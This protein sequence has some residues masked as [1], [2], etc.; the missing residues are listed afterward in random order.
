MRESERNG[1][2][3]ASIRLDSVQ[4]EG[5]SVS[6]VLSYDPGAEITY[7]K[8]SLTDSTLVKTE[9]LQAYLDIREGGI[10]Y[11][12]TLNSL[13]VRMD[14]LEFIGLDGAPTL[15]FRG[16]HADISLPVKRQRSNRIDAV[17]GFLPNEEND[18]GL[19]VTGE[20]ELHLDNLFSSGKMFDLHWQRMRPETQYL[21]IAYHHPNLFRSNI[22]ASGS[23]QLLKEDTTFVSRDAGL[24]FA[25]RNGRHVI[26]FLSRFRASR[27]L[28]TESDLAELPEIAD[29]NLNDYGLA[30]SYHDRRP[31][32][33]GYRGV[34]LSSDFR[35]GNKKIRQ[36]TAF[37]PEFYE[38]LDTDLLQLSA[39]ADVKWGFLTGKQTL[40]YQHLQAGWMDA[41]VLFFNDLY[42]L[43]GFRSIRGFNENQFFAQRYAL[44]TLECQV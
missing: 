25:Y 32:W 14:A 1:Y 22:D 20:A 21:M 37:P 43:G 13:A 6:A 2:P 40:L 28:E 12:R 38:G 5:S 17:I 33:Q 18:G 36:N 24:R 27:L 39:E 10:Y 35:I 9:W 19:R 34:S 8:L 26:S 11:Q 41:D 7:G 30:Y 15:N 29:F 4:L 44:Y 3:L 31:G 42:R 23:F 16:T